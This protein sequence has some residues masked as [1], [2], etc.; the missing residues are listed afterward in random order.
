MFVHHDLML[1]AFPI[2]LE[3]LGVEP[4]SLINAEAD[5]ANMAIVG[6]FIPHI[7]IWDLDQLDPIEP[8]L[9]LLGVEDRPTI[10]KKKKG[11]KKISAEQGHSDAVVSLS[12]NH[13]RK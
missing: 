7:E 5:R 1:S 10:S 9:V 3:W 4:S 8:T 6:S 11:A 13:F 12:L 2:C